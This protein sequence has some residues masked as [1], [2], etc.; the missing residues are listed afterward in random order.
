MGDNEVKEA[1]EVA[2]KELNYEID[3]ICINLD[4]ILGESS[5]SKAS[6][7][8]RLTRVVALLK[9]RLAIP[10]H[11]KDIF[12]NA[13]L[14]QRIEAFMLYSKDTDDIYTLIGEVFRSLYVNFILS[15][16]SSDESGFMIPY[17]GEITIHDRVKD[18]TAGKGDSQKIGSFKM[19]RNLLSDLKRADRDEQLIVIQDLLDAAAKSS[20][21]LL[22]LEISED[23][24]TNNKG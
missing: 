16:L 2:V 7:K 14:Y 4:R 13:D 20:R 18:E 19:N 23:E 11:G 12:H 17:L 24:V 3:Q 1:R 9:D 21:E 22:R 8:Q 6:S 10:G 15:Y 5:S